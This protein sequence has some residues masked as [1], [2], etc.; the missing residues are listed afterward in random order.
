M[1]MG[2]EPAPMVLRGLLA[3]SVYGLLPVDSGITL[4]LRKRTMINLWFNSVPYYF[5]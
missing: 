5:S 1:R 4:P 2:E 3:K